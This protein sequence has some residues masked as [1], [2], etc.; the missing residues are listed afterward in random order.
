MSVL[1]LDLERRFEQRWPPDFPGRRNPPRTKSIGLKSSVSLHRP[2][3]GKEKLAG[4][5]RRV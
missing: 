4:L 2:A 3:K 1:P 5:S